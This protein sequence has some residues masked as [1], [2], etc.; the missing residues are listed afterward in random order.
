MGRGASAI[1][2]QIRQQVISLPSDTMRIRE[3]LVWTERSQT[4]H[5]C[6]GQNCTEDVLKTLPADTKSMMEGKCCVQYVQVSSGR[7]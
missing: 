2:A 3:R 1:E 5:D 7:Y 4:L 6:L